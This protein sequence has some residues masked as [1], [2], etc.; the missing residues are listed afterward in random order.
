M[1]LR[2]ITAQGTSLFDVFYRTGRKRRT[3]DEILVEVRDRFACLP[4]GAVTELAQL[5]RVAPDEVRMRAYAA[6]VP[7]VD[8]AGALSPRTCVITV[9]RGASCHRADGRRILDTAKEV[10]GCSPGDSTK[11]GRFRLECAECLDVCEEGPALAVN[12]EVHTRLTPKD[13]RRLLG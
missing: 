9:C 5:C 1:D 8:G 13:V 6:R 7:I 3:L 11:D 2:K 12:R 10:L 4:G